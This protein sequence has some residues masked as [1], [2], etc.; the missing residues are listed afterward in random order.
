MYYDELIGRI[1]EYERKKYFISD[2]YKPRLKSKIQK[3]RQDK[4]KKIIGIEK[5]DNIKISIDTDN[6]LPHDITFKNA[7]ILITGVI[8]DDSKF[9]R[10]K[11][12]KKK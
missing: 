3:I 6:K 5:A 4:I 12:R 11:M 2:D 1:E 7:V 8:K 10:Q 9:Y